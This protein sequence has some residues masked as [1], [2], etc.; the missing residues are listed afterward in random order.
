MAVL[1]KVYAAITAF[2]F[3]SGT[4]FCLGWSP[5]PIIPARTA[6]SCLR[7]VYNNR[8]LY[9][10]DG[11]QER[12]HTRGGQ[13]FLSSATFPTPMADPPTQVQDPKRRLLL[14]GAIASMVVATAI[15]TSVQSV[16]ALGNNKSRTEGY[17]FQRSP[18]EWRSMLSPSQYDILRNGATERPF[19][20]ILEGEKRHGIFN[21]AGCGTPLFDSS[22]KFSSGT[23]WPSFARALDG[24][25]IEN[26]G[27]AQ[28][29]FVGAELRCRTCGGHL[30]D[31][32]NDGFLF[33]GT[34]AF[35]SGKRFCIDGAAL[36]FR[37][38][39]GDEVVGDVP[40][41]KK[42]TPDWLSPPQIQARGR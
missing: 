22:E 36:V 23:G 15:T 8:D 31:I 24:V 12:P 25:E 29:N 41:P 37:S 28:A 17:A 3:A 35:T 26:V 18:V 20:S 27:A 21:C 19:S 34:P 16:D 33:V 38:E 9:E 4:T 7:A 39:D 1:C 6:T 14:N 11:H 42:P 10:S 40:P 2:A 30:G 13:V 32:F 5:T